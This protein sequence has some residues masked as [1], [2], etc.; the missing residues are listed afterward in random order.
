MAS[1]LGQM[2]RRRA[3]ALLGGD[4]LATVLGGRA[5]SGRQSGVPL[6]RARFSGLSRDETPSFAWS[7]GGEWVALPGNGRIVA[8]DTETGA[9]RVLWSR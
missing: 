3:L 7:P 9:E 5:G 1:G 8:W 4:A 2:G 6:S